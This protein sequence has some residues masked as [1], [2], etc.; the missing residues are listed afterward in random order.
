MNVKAWGGFSPRRHAENARDI[1]R[2]G[3]DLA[4]EKGHF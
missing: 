1:T 2:K 3:R 4:R